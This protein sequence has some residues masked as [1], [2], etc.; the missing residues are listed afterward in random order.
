MKASLKVALS[1]VALCLPLA[2]QAAGD[3]AAGSI[4]FST[5]MGCHG[6]PDYANVYPSYR[7]PHLGGQHPQYIISALKEYRN[8]NRHHPTMSA[9]AQSLTE[10]DIADIAAFLSQAPHHH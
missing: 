5:C 8:G 3:P 4:K 2:A 9:Q 7:V 6:I 1:M 10:Q